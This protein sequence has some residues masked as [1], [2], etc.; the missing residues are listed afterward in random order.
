MRNYKKLCLLAVIAA[1]AAL[2]LGSCVSQ[3]EKQSV[4][5]TTPEPADWPMFRFSLDRC[6]YNATETI[7][8]PPLELKWKFK[9][10]S[11]I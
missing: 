2:I 8:K 11:K 6:G 1:T 9:A 10:K 5:P 4:T 3:P 7:L